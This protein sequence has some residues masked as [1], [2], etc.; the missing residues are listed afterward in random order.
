M[1]KNK[2]IIIGLVF[3]V[4]VMLTTYYLYLDKP[5]QISIKSISNQYSLK[6]QDLNK[7]N[8]FLKYINNCENNLLTTYIYNPNPNITKVK[9]AEV[10]LTDNNQ[11]ITIRNSLGQLDHTYFSDTIN[12]N[13]TLYLN[14]NNS[15]SSELSLEEHVFNVL[16]L[17]LNYFLN[18]RETNMDYK[19]NFN[20]FEDIGIQY[21]QK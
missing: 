6:L 10:I 3:L 7:F 9:K 17:Q 14:P 20:N 15:N 1:K 8:N 4:V 5:C 2:I 16:M 12:T 18:G 19:N 13:S 21:V 11:I